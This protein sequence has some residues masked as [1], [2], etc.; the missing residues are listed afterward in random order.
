MLWS[1]AFL[2]SALLNSWVMA[3][4]RACVPASSST[5]AGAGR[6]RP[7]RVGRDSDVPALG[8]FVAH[9][10]GAAVLGLKG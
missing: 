4:T 5:I 9:F 3:G 10:G 1:G 6:I 2:F 7:R 8:T